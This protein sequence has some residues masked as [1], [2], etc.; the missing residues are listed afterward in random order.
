MGAD[1]DADP[2][3]FAI[4]PALSLRRGQKC[5]F[6]RF[7]R[8]DDHGLRNRI[9]GNSAPGVQSLADTLGPMALAG[10]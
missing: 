10:C 4:I 9:G 3:V 8:E 5:A 2:D 7:E 1:F 6:R